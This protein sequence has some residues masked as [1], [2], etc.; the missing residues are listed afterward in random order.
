MTEKFRA[1]VDSVTEFLQDMIANELPDESVAQAIA[2]FMVENRDSES[3]ADFAH[4][5]DGETAEGAASK[6]TMGG[7]D[8]ETAEGAASKMTMG[9]ADSVPVEDW[10]DDEEQIAFGKFAYE[11]FGIETA[12]IRNLNEDH[13]E[14]ILDTQGTRNPA[15]TGGGQRVVRSGKPNS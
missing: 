5:A 12:M 8:G 14:A 2:A 13:K 15:S 4:W 1:G 10:I 7:A 6:M 11:E 9:G 3:T